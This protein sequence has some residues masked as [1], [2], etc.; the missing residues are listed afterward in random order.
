MRTPLSHLT[1][2]LLATALAAGSTALAQQAP[3]PP[4]FEDLSQPTAEV[5]PHPEYVKAIART[6]YV[7]GWP[8][9]NMLNRRARITQAPEPGLLGGIL[10][11]APQGQVGMLHDYIDPAETFV[12]LPEPG[13]GLRPRVLRSRQPAGGRAG[14]RFR[15][16]LL[17]LCALRSA[18]RPVRR[19]RQ[20]L[21]HQA[22]LLP[23]GRPG[24]ERRG[25]RRHHR[26]DPVPDL[27]RQRH[28]ARLHERHRRGPESHPARDRP[29]RRLSAVG[30]R[31]RD[32][33]DRLERAARHP[34]PRATGF[35]ARPSGWCRRSSSTSS[36]R[37]WTW[38]RR[39]PAKRRSTRSSAG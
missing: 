9:V 22:R 31:R 36:P 39:C 5:T 32:E 24:L 20:A 2:A 28:S 25:A 35:A 14:A 3:A 16:P 30:V 38:C 18:H 34:R 37:C 29:D 7:W 23:A 12:D 27:A 11:V 21:R 13:R 17:G 6:A 15:R 8:M 4:S 10:P 33:D 19:A 1:A 26:R